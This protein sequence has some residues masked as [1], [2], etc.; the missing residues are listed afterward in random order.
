[1]PSSTTVRMT[2]HFNSGTTFAVEADM[3]DKRHR[4]MAGN[5]EQAMTANWLGVELEGTLHVFPPQSIRAI[6]ITPAP[7]MVIKHV[8]RDVRRAR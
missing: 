1:M 6:E 4:N 2:I 7:P 8:V 5:I 3:D